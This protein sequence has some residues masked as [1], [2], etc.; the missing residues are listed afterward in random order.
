MIQELKIENFRGFESLHFQDLQQV[1]LIVGRNNAGKTSLLEAIQTLCFP[2]GTLNGLEKLIAEFRPSGPGDPNPKGARWLVRDGA[3][4]SVILYGS[5][6]G[7]WGEPP[8]IKLDLGTDP[9]SLSNTQW[10]MHPIASAGPVYVF[11]KPLRQTAKKISVHHE[12]PAALVKLV[13][14]VNRTRGSEQALERLLQQVD[15]RI[16]RIR[17]DPGEDPEKPENQV[18]VDVGLG[19]ALPLTQAGQGMYRLVSILGTLLGDRPDILLID[20]IETG[21]HHTVLEDVWKG[22]AAAARELKVQVFATTHSAECIAAAH[23]AFADS[24]TYDF[25]IL[26]LFRLKTGIQGRVLDRNLIEA[27]IEGEIEFR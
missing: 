18:T 16:S 13:G 11:G 10:G 26:Q 4:H 22:I 7:P 2:H 20:E 12:D 15:G 8:G 21:L 9:Q 24:T 14:K 6:S 27:G 5:K 3:T 19:E 23:R 17:V 25:R 1:N